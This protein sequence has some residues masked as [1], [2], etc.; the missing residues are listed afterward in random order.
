[1]IFNLNNKLY[2]T[3]KSDQNVKLCVN[4]IGENRFTYISAFI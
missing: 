4:I 2:T 1:M 3:I